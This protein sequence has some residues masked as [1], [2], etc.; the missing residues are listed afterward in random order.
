MPE[1]GFLLLNGDN[2]LIRANPPRHRFMTYGLND[3]NDY[4]ASDVKVSSRGTAFTLHT[5]DGQSCDFQ[6]ALLGEH[7]I[8]NLTGALAMCHLLGIPLT[9]LK[10]RLLKI[11][12][13]PHRLQLIDHGSF[14][15]IDDGFNSNPNGTQAA[16]RTLSLFDDYKIMITPGMVELGEAQETLNREFGQNAARICD[17]VILVG[18][19]Q[20]RP[21]ARGLA[22]A[23]FPAEKDRKSVV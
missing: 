17:Y 2:E 7:N 10:P 20:T 12:A 5:P 21:I 1:D 18:E 19:K 3:E 13:V 14:A 16:L 4:R 6:T 11:T 23:G 15:V 8:V 9:A 22:D